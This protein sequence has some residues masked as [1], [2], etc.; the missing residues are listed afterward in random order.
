M[1]RPTRSTPRPTNVRRAPASRRR[2]RAAARARALAAARRAAVEAQRNT[3]IRAA[4]AA[5]A[6]L[7]F[8][9]SFCDESYAFCDSSPT[10]RNASG[11]QTAT[12]VSSSPLITASRRREAAAP[13]KR[14][15]LAEYGAGAERRGDAPLSVHH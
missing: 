8:C 15:A 10:P 2:I 9:A 5:E 4:R 12:T 3:N 11:V 14:A 1:R 7:A 6:R 13:K